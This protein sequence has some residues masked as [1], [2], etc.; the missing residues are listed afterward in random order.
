M[1]KYT[2]LYLDEISG[3]A[4]SEP[5]FA[6]HVFVIILQN[7]VLV[8]CIRTAFV[9]TILWKFMTTLTATRY[10]LMA[11]TTSICSK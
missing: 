10:S 4:I 8:S 11:L 6:A 1:C 2:L 7:E 5:Y 3:K 9:K